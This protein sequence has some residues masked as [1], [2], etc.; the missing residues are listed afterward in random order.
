MRLEQTRSPDDQLTLQIAILGRT[1]IE[2]GSFHKSGMLLW[3]ET[4]RLTWVYALPLAGRFKVSM[5]AELVRGLP[6]S[7]LA[8]AGVWAALSASASRRLTKVSLSA[9]GWASPAWHLQLVHASDAS[10]HRRRVMRESSPACQPLGE[11]P[12]LLQ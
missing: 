4:R 9:A 7:S 3:G 1:I 11:A 6:H 8:P 5:T 10:Y 12:A 2:L